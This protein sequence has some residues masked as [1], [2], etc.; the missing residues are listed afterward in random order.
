MTARHVR[1]SQ[2]PRPIGE[3]ADEFGIPARFVEAHG[4]HKAKIDLQVLDEGRA[5]RGK[6][7]LVSAV[8]PTPLGE[9]K[10]TT[11]IGLGMAFARLNKRAVVTLR[12]SSLGPAFGIKGGGAGGGA[13]KLIPL[14]DSILHV[15]G[16]LY[17]VAQAHNQL[18]ALTD[19]SC[20][21]GNPCAIDLGRIQLR[22]VLDVNDRYLRQ[23]TI[24]LGGKANGEPR[25][26]GFDITAAS[27]LMAVLALCDG[28]TAL[29]AL[30]DLR[31]RIGRM[32]V[33]FDR[34]GAPVTAERLQAAGAA[35]V[36][37]REALKPTL[38]QTAEN[39]PVLLHTGP[40]GNIA[41]GNCSVLA[42]RVAL[43]FADYVV[44]E[45]GFGSD[46]GGEKFFDIKCRTSGLKP[47]VAV[48]VCT[49]RALKVH[50]GKHSVTAGKPLPAALLEE[51]AAD[52]RLGAE[53]LAAHIRILRA[54]GTPVVV[55]IN[56]FPE[57]R[58]S[59]LAVID[60]VARAASADAVVTSRAFVKGGE[61]AVEL[62]EAVIA[63]ATRGSDYRLLYP[64]EMSLREKI[65][66]LAT[67]I[68]GAAEAGLSPLAAEQ[69]AALEGAGFGKLPVCMAKTH[70]SLSHDPKLKGAPRGYLFPVREVRIS[71]GA[72]FIYP[73][74][75]EMMTMPGLGASPAAY[76][77]DIDAD[78]NTVGLF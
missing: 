57:D 32:V 30:K 61:G 62:A 6:Y 2:V 19:N 69:L 51:N 41:H 24:G 77:I 45:A 20:Y 7:V 23:V 46:M 74:A 48:L 66:L 33:A 47:D 16:D 22:R 43:A 37:L 1:P 3:I 71:A 11:A 73:L 18:A 78:G 67:R 35:T 9:G 49:V 12:Q 10:T 52:V 59:E 27:E 31:A 40:F 36:L 14:E 29:A 60:E 75:G 26:A 38:M 54:F 53:N 72:G 13:A 25:E 34:A 17:A 55:A 5:R 58:A 76:G 8:T 56:G 15:T 44:T 4:R 28:T 21:H 42:D 63:A 50:S 65:E 68:Y 64:L 39:T 70:L